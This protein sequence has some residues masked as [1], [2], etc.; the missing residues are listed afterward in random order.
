MRD[1]IDIFVHED[2]ERTRSKRTPRAAQDASSG[3]VSA[4]KP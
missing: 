2:C 1:A 4:S 3:E